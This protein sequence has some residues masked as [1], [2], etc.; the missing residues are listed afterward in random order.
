[1]SVLTAKYKDILR[2]QQ[3]VTEDDYLTE[4]QNGKLD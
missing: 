3:N 2:K 4:I 1:M